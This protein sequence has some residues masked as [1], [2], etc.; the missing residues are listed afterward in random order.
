MSIKDNHRQ[1][2]HNFPRWA[3][4]MCSRAMTAL[5]ALGQMNKTLFLAQLASPRLRTLPWALTAW[6]PL[7]CLR[8]LRIHCNFSGRELLCPGKHWSISSFNWRRK[9]SHI[10]LSK[11]CLSCN[12]LAWEVQKNR[13]PPVHFHLSQGGSWLLGHLVQVPQGEILGMQGQSAPFCS[14]NTRP[15][16]IPLPRITFCLPAMCLIPYFVNWILLSFLFLNLSWFSQGRCSR[17]QDTS[18]E[19]GHE[20]FLCYKTVE[21]QSPGNCPAPGVIQE[22]QLV[23]STKQESSQHVGVTTKKQHQ[24]KGSGDG[25]VPGES[26]WVA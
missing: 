15:G 8:Y 13:L 2:K 4:P 20:D 21:A 23:A 7:S 26:S 6:A 14:C 12:N 9:H 17:G 16:E 5:A 11:L 10:C 25:A 19:L 18:Q 3:A 24:E 22:K 1:Q